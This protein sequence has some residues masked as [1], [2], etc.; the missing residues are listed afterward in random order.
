VTDSVK[1]TNNDKYIA[2]GIIADTHVDALTCADSPLL[3]PNFDYYNDSDWMKNNRNVINDLNLDCKKTGR[4]FVDA[5]VKQDCLGI[6]HLGDMVNDRSTQQLVAFRQLY[7]YD[8]SHKDVYTWGCDCGTRCND[9]YSQGFRIHFPVI[10]VLGNHDVT[11]S[12]RDQNTE[13][14]GYIIQRVADAKGLLDQY[15]NVIDPANNSRNQTNFIWRWG[16]YVFVTLGLWAGSYNWEDPNHIDENK[17]T[18]LKNSLANYVGDS[19]LGV[20]IFQHYGWD[21]FSTMWW[22]DDQRDK[23]LNILCRRENKNDVCNPYN[24][25]GIFTGHNHH[26]QR[27]IK[28]YAGTDANGKAV[29]FENFSML[30][31]AATTHDALA[32]G[33]SVVRLT[34]DKMYIHTK[35]KF[36]DAFWPV[37]VRD[38]KVGK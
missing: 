32:Y 12:Y 6:V 34:G 17:L 35:D 25:L 22:S 2:F 30:T 38:I 4:P 5:V 21:G 1:V 11:H 9:A 15:P 28:V 14:G 19:N 23:M 33:F 24:V 36:G 7:E 18:W 16:Q 10:P 20:L 37:T 13:T 27:W 3:C 26:P 31:T 29:E 8:Y